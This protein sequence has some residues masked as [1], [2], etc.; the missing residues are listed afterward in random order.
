VVLLAQLLRGGTPWQFDAYLNAFARSLTPLAL[1]VA[2][3]FVL[4]TALGS[5]LAGA[6]AAVY[7]IA[8]PLARAHLPAVLDVTMTQHWPMVALFALGLLG[9]TIVY[10]G[11][12][13]SGVPRRGIALGTTVL[14]VGGVLAALAINARGYDALTEPDPVLSAM[15]HQNA[16]AGAPAPGFWLQD[17]QHRIVGLGDY[18][19]KPIVLV[20]WGPAEPS[21]ADL[22]PTLSK[23]ADRYREQQLVPIAICLDKD[24]ATLAPFARGVGKRV[25]MLWDPGSHFTQAASVGDVP[26][27]ASAIPWVESPAS[28]AYALETVPAVF[29]IDRNRVLT[30]AQ[31]MMEPAGLETAVAQFVGAR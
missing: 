31:G 24:S 2:L 23:L 13:I 3:G 5:A 18:V 29:L 12:A 14:L 7:W 8:V 30:E 17:A 9:L 27:E 21:S 4:T 10:H 11:K 16:K 20:F 15:A 28:A 25:V 1:A 26:G 19:G 22:L 6:I